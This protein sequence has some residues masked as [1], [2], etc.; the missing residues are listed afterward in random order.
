[1]AI[2]EPEFEITAFQLENILKELGFDWELSA[3][4]RP[5]FIHKLRGACFEHLD[6]IKQG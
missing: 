1:M 2:P 3:N 5:E 6:T 4:S